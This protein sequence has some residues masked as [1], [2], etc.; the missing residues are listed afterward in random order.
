MDIQTKEQIIDELEKVYGQ[1]IH[2]LNNHDDQLFEQPEAPEKWSAGQHADHLIKSTAPLR[3]GLAMPTMA[4]RA[5]FGTNNR[6]EYAFE[7]LKEKYKNGLAAG[8]QA[9]GR[10]VPPPIHND[11]KKELIAQLEYELT[12]LKKVLG[13]WDEKKMSKFILPH[14]LLGKLSV[15][16]MMFFTVFHTQHHLDILKERY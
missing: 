9:T 13:K 14:P 1:L 6:E 12:G 4:L 10:F 5:T 8:G 16:E 11:Q 15:R 3:K 2:W 7:A